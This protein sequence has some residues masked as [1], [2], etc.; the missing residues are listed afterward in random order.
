MVNVAYY[1]GGFKPIHIGHYTIVQQILPKVS[2]LYILISPK[3]RGNIT[4]EDSLN[5][6]NTYLT[7]EQKTK[8]RVIITK[9][10][11]I[12]EIFN[13]LR[14]QKFK[15]TDTIYLIKSSKNAHNKRFDMFHKL[16]YNITELQIPKYK[17]LSSTNMRKALDNKDYPRFNK[18]LPNHLSSKDKKRI[19]NDLID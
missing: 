19:Y 12:M 5:M 4:A 15:P 2:M 13:I 18:F 14:I 10:N 3:P 9:G 17:N 8:T 1:P 6:W 16:N 7:P 11:P